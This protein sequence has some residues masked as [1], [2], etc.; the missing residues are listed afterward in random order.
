M[1]K[2]SSYTPVDPSKT[3]PDSRPKWEKSLGQ[4]GANTLPI[5]A[6]HTHKAYIREYVPECFKIKTVIL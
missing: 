4:N 5:G 3:I 6:A 2:I 1:I